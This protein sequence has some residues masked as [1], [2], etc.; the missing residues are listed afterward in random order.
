VTEDVTKR[1]EDLRTLLEA[2]RSLVLDDPALSA[3][4]LEQLQKRCLESSE[5]LMRDM[6]TLDSLVAATPEEKAKRKEQVVTIQSILDSLD[7]VSE[8]LRALSRKI[9]EQKEQMQ[10]EKEEA[11]AKAQE[12]ASQLAR[13]SSALTCSPTDAGSLE[14]L[15]A[16]RRD[17]EARQSGL[18]LQRQQS[19]QQLGD[20][21]EHIADLLLSDAAWKALKLAPRFDVAEQP[22]AY[23]LKAFVPDL[24]TEDIAVDL[25]AEGTEL[26]VQGARIPT[27]PQ[28]AAMLEE[29][30]YALRSGRLDPER[31]LSLNDEQV[32]LV[33][34][35]GRYGTFA[36]RV[37]L[38][39]DAEPAGVRA[40]NDRGVLKVTIPK[41]A[42]P[43]F[44][45][46]FPPP[47]ERRADPLA[48]LHRPYGLYGPAP[49]YR[50]APAYD[51]LFW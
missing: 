43:S 22:A 12:E 33:L 45:R 8:K 26:V 2:S 29:L 36:Q 3:Q 24:R 1:Q 9:H 28:T 27:R 32:L 17:W 21:I 15:E 42:A 49:A 5:S 11:L 50:P 23:L 44:R 13:S 7:D 34:G 46:L 47:P 48:A 41:R 10:K 35:S 31:L 30:A 14:A 38:L 37:R 18:A 6:L 16:Q 4:A 19:A 20:R 51:S 39:D 40:D 25:N